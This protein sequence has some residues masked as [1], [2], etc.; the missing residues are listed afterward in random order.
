ME[1]LSDAKNKIKEIKTNVNN[2]IQRIKEL[3]STIKRKFS[4]LTKLI[5]ISLSGDLSG[6]VMDSIKEIIK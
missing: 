4:S 5:F 6:V 3:F 2:R 1:K